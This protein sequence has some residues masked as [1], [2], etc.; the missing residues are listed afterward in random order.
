MKTKQIII[1]I[2]FLF[3]TQ[4]LSAQEKGDTEKAFSKLTW[5][6]ADQVNN[7]NYA[8]FGYEKG[9]ELKNEVISS[10]SNY[11]NII[12]NDD[13]TFIGV[14]KNMKFFFSP[15]P[16]Y[17]PTFYVLNS[18]NKKVLEFMGEEMCVKSSGIIYVTG[19]MNQV[20][21]VHKKYKIQGETIKEVKQPYMYVGIKDKLKKPIK[22]YNKQN[23]SGALVARLPKGYEVEILLASGTK[24]YLVK[25]AFGL[26]GWLTIEQEDT[27]I[28]NSII[29]GLGY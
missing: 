27:Y 10:N 21:N 15:G 6:D 14:F 4:L 26:V 16:S 12:R 8:R 22:L 1:G 18:T 23:K 2:I 25:T 7:E 29:D 3:S 17:D 11:H 24:N 20:F 13:I 5:V 19:N 28:M 9:F